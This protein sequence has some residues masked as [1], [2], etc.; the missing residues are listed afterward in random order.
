MFCRS[1]ISVRSLPSRYWYL[2]TYQK[3][4]RDVERECTKAV[5][6]KREQAH[7]VYLLHAALWDLPEESN[8]E[9]HDSTNGSEVVQRYEGIHLVIGRVQN[10]LDQIES[11]GFENNAA[12]LIDHT[13]PHK[14][15]LAN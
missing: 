13:D 2:E 8:S 4:N 1:E 6:E 11:E 14:L 12:N 5:E 3:D 7:I 10:A 9:V 15:D